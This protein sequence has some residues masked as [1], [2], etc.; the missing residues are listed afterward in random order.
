V[1]DIHGARGF[2]VFAYLNALKA[3]GAQM[4]PE[5]AMMTTIRNYFSKTD[6]YEVIHSPP[7]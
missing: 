6:R 1:G 5:A 3:M 2:G 4:P 7:N